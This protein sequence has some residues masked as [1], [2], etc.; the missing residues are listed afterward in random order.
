M[1]SS[2]E[3]KLSMYNAVITY[4]DA[5]TA[6][7]ATV[8]AFQT[9]YTNFKNN[10]GAIIEVASLEAQVITGITMDKSQMRKDLAQKASDIAAAVYAYAITQN[11][12][13]LKEQVNFSVSDLLR[14]KD[15]ILGP[16]CSN[17]ANA[18]DTNIANLAGYGITAAVLT[19]FA[20]MTQAFMNLV[21]APRNAVTQRATYSSELKELFKTGDSILKDQMDKIALQFKTTNPEFYTTYK[22]NR[23]IL[24]AGTSPTQAEGIIT[25]NGT[26]TTLSGV[27]IQVVGQSYNATSNGSGEYKLKIPVPGTYNIQFTKSGFA[28]K[29]VDNIEITLGQSTDLDVQLDAA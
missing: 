13:T 16:T 18:A 19:D 7:V 11:D 25:Q 28:D 4:C 20:D 29:T 12:N 15:E 1:N 9:A 26:E 22:N 17:I 24:D 3:A 14:L 21:A 6:T 23:I 8:P 10:F 27:S 2:Q 5:N